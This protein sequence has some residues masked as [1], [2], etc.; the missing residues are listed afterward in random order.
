MFETYRINHVGMAVPNIERYLKT[1]ESL[2]RGFNRSKLII[3][4]AQGVLELFMNDGYTTLELL[5]PLNDSSP[6]KQFLHHH[7]M[8]GLVHVCYECNDVSKAIEQLTVSGAKLV[9]GPTPD[10]AFDGK[11]VAFMFFGGQLIELVNW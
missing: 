5:E 11:P 1:C 3:N 6:I 7:I 2:Y 10:V 8:G 4:D 9:N